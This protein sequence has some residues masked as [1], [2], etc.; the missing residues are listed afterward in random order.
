MAQF[1]DGVNPDLG[2]LQPGDDEFLQEL[3]GSE[4]PTL[5]SVNT[6]VRV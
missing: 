5:D 6:L 4:V 1:A 2:L 3:L